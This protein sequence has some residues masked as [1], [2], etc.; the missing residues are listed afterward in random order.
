[1]IVSNNFRKLTLDK[2]GILLNFKAPEKKKIL[3]SDL[4]KIYITVNKM[5]TIYEVLIVL[6]AISVATF[7][8]INFQIDLILITAFLVAIAIIL[9]KNDYKS[10]SLQLRLKNG[11]IF[12]NKVQSKSKHET[13]DTVNEVRK[14][15]YKIKKRNEAL[16]SAL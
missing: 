5:R 3:F 2:N 4:E 14:E 16:L 7:L 10:Y 6:S 9:K 15:I 8:Y 12:K 1:M 11:E 13:I